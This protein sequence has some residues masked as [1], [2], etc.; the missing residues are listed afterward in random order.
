MKKLMILT[1]DQHVLD[2]VRA[3]FEPQGFELLML[4]SSDNV[5]TQVLWQKPNVLLLDF[6]LSE[7]NGGSICH[8]IKSHQALTNV[9]VILLSEFSEPNK[10]GCDAWLYKPVDE[11]QLIDTVNG[12]VAK[13]AIA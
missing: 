6:L 3:A 9:P 7:N 11:R 10:F 8:Q 2:I 1:D 13:Y 4:N 12:C 5:I